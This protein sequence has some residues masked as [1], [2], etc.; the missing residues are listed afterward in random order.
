M[1]RSPTLHT[2]LVISLTIAA[3]LAAAVALTIAS[4]DRALSEVAET[5]YRYLA[6][7]IRQSVEAGLGLGLGLAELD[8]VGRVIEERLARD[9]DMT[10]LRIETTDGRVVFAAERE[11]RPD[12]AEVTEPLVNAFGQRAGRL[13]IRYATGRYA[14]ITERVGAILTSRAVLLATLAAGLAVIGCGLVLGG[15]PRSL[16]R[17]RRRLT[18]EPVEGRMAEIE[19]TAA[20]AAESADA[21]LSDLAALERRIGQEGAER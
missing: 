18:G 20:A 13:V 4:F 9:A 19:R 12:E 15:I 1:L 17:A 2:A 5:R 16:D 6:A 3:T 14:S 21:T 10:A 7:D 11:G 8:N